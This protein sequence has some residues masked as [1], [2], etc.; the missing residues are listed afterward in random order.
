MTKD[1]L[2]AGKLEP[3][4]EGPY[5]IGHR[6]RGG[7]YTLLDHDGTLLGR[8]YA[9]SQLIA[10]PCP[11]LLVD[12]DSVFTVDR[13]VAHRM[14]SAGRYE[15]YV[16]WRGYDDAHDSWE[17]ASSFFDVT[18]IT[19]YWR[20]TPSADTQLSKTQVDQPATIAATKRFSTRPMAGIPHR[21][22][23]EK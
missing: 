22:R 4:H 23:L 10:V 18:T 12:S 21:F 9:P 16:K 5:K 7:T 13:I 6:N 17:P 20:T 19:A 15:Y 1:P 11:S 8:N 3:R 14:L 2:R